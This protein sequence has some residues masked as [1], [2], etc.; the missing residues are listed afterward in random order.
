MLPFW[1][2]ECNKYGAKDTKKNPDGTTQTDGNGNPIYELDFTFRVPDLR[3]QFISSTYID[4]I[5]SI[6]SGATSSG[7]KGGK[8]VVGAWCPDKTPPSSTG[9][10]ADRHAHFISYGSWGKKYHTGNISISHSN[11]LWTDISIIKDIS[12]NRDLSALHQSEGS[13]HVFLLHNHPYAKK[14]E[15]KDCFRGFGWRYNTCSDGRH[16]GI[17][18]IPATIWLSRPSVS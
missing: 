16:S 13:P 1:D 14:I 18:S 3:H 9:F 6:A 17:D 10:R 11:K 4:G 2:T 5:T 8:N 7:I 15:G 12:F